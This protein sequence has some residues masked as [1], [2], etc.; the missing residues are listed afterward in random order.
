MLAL[1][2]HQRVLIWLLTHLE[3]MTMFGALITLACGI[4]T[5]GRS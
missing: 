5:L 2:H 1:N 3:M 4:L